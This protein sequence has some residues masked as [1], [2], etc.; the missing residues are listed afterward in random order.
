MQVPG[1]L[2]LQKRI[3][4]L[5]FG[6]RWIWWICR[7]PAWHLG[8]MPRVPHEPWGD[9]SMRTRGCI[10]GNCVI[11]ES[12]GSTRSLPSCPV[13]P[14]EWFGSPIPTVGN[15]RIENQT[16]GCL[17]TFI[18]SRWIWWICQGPD[19]LGSPILPVAKV[20]EAC[21]CSKGSLQSG[22]RQVPT[23]SPMAE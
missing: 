9:L 20:S 18:K 14:F 16:R 21:T 8:S 15:R 4:I 6:S 12:G 7:G 19:C 13:D 10:W 1:I 23:D 3:E 5:H 22:S 17:D 11:S 2:P